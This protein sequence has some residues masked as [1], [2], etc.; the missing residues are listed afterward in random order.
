MTLYSLSSFEI[1][2]PL[3]HNENSPARYRTAIQES[4]FRGQ[5]DMQNSKS[6]RKMLVFLPFVFLF[7]Q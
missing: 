5:R 2:S 3:L 4:R 1:E 6:R 7:R